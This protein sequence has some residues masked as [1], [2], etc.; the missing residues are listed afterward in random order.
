MIRLAMYSE[1]FSKEYLEVVRKKV[2]KELQDNI[3]DSCKLYMPKDFFDT[4]EDEFEQLILA[5]F[6]KLK[7]AYEYINANTHSKMEYECFSCNNNKKTYNDMYNEYV[8]K[9][10]KVSQSE[11]DGKKMSVRM[12]EELDLTICPYCNREYINSRD[13]DCAGAQLDHFYNKSTYPIFSL[14]LY[15]LVPV[16]GNCNRIKSSKKC[17]FASP[18][19]LDIDFDNGLKFSL[20]TDGDD[21]TRIQIVV[22]EDCKKLRNNISE[23]KIENSY[24]IHRKDVLEL[25]KKLK[26][27]SDTQLQEMF[28]IT[29]IPAI[30]IK[31]MIFGPKIDSNIM[32]NKTLGRMLHDLQEIYKIFE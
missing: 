21:I 12:V 5:E 31:E 26:Q 17:D 27:Y 29:N 3:L 10:T 1:Q 24:Q 6:P 4:N 25:Q 20:L 15:N 22:N 2:S 8:D 16:C 32:K 9:Y 18:F 30:Q 7:K 19:D 28:K 23:M 11:Y 14:C 13:E